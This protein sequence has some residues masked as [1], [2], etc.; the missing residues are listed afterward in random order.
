MKN[1]MNFLTDGIAYYERLI[2]RIDIDPS[3]DITLNDWTNRDL[4]VSNKNVLED[5]ITQY[6]QYG[7]DISRLR[8]DEVKRFLEHLDKFEFNG[9]LRE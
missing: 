4:L 1:L 2:K 3:L 5:V 6:T 9:D 7:I 8:E